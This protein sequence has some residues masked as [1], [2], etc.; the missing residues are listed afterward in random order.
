MSPPPAMRPATI[1][2]LAAAAAS[3]SASANASADLLRRADAHRKAGG[4]VHGAGAW[5]ECLHRRRLQSS[6]YKLAFIEYARA[7]TLI[8]ST[9]EQRAN[10]T[11]NG[12]RILQ[13]LGQLK[14]ALVD[15]YERYA[16]SPGVRTDAVPA[17][18]VSSIAIA[19]ENHPTPAVEPRHPN[20]QSFPGDT[21]SDQA[22]R[23]GRGGAVSAAPPAALPMSLARSSARQ[24]HGGQLAPMPASLG[25]TNS[26][27]GAR[28][29][30][31]AYS[32]Y[33]T[34]ANHLESCILDMDLDANPVPKL[35]QRVDPRHTHPGP[36]PLRPPYAAYEW[37]GDSSTDEEQG[38]TISLVAKFAYEVT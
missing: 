29:G 37:D 25:R 34:S 20:S 27:Q 26:T 32:A 23:R 13:H 19:I 5:F 22:G 6:E 8:G 12:Q 17:F 28:A 11:A 16:Q 9:G 31:G 18:M 33:P 4:C 36:L 21:C 2:E 38:Q 14:A 15:R 3:S 30:T 35:Q 7:A 1:S 10:P 24:Y